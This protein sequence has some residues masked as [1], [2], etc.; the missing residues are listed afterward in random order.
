MGKKS[1][2]EKIIPKRN[3]IL[4]SEVI[5]EAKEKYPGYNLATQLEQ[6]QYLQGKIFHAGSA[7]QVAAVKHKLASL[8]SNAID[9]AYS[10]EARN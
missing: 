3:L 1:I 8:L 6:Y 9:Y 2:N 7:K 4:L 5:K 10:K